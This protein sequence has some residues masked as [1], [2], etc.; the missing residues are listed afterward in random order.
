MKEQG[1][2]EHCARKRMKRAKD[3]RRGRVEEEA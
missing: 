1:M 2:L 3:E